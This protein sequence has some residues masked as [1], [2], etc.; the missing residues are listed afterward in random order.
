MN[1]LQTPRRSYRAL[2]KWI[3]S[4]AESEF[5]PQERMQQVRVATTIGAI[6]GFLFSLFNLATP[7]MQT[8]GLIELFAVACLATPALII[9]RHRH[10]VGFAETMLLLAAILI[11]GA[12]IVLGGV[13][14]TGLFW[15][16]TT[17]FLAFF[18]KG[19]RLGRFY[20]IG[21]LIAAA[22][23][24]MV[25]APH[26][27]FARHY[28][29]VISFHFL[30]SLGFYTLVA[31]A[32]D[33]V[34]TRYDDQLRKEKEKAE[35]AYMAK[36]RFL[37]AA[38]HDLRQPAHALG[39]F[40]SRLLQMPADSRTSEIVAGVDASTRA[41][42]EMLDVFF[43]YSRLESQSAEVVLRPVAL[44]TLLEQL[45][46]FFNG[47]AAEKGLRLRFR[48]TGAWVQ[49]DPVLLQRIL[50]NLVSNAL[51]YTER[52]TVL[53]ACRPSHDRAHLR[54]EVWDSGIGIAREHHKKIFEEFFQVENQQR[55]RTKGLGLGLS[56]VGRSCRILNHPLELRSELGCGSRF[57]LKVPLAP[58]GQTKATPHE[59]TSGLAIGDTDL[60]NMHILLIEDDALGSSALV[61]LLQSWGCSV[62]LTQSAQDALERVGRMP[63][64]DF[65]VSDF[66]LS[67]S[68]NGVE[69]IDLLRE[70]FGSTLK[71][72]L[73]SGDT[74]EDVK[75]KA[76]TASLVLLQK[77]VAPGKLRSVL[78]RSR[79]NAAV[80]ATAP[81]ATRS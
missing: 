19:Q 56:M 77:P 66:R 33:Y 75:R 40:V 23:Y 1:L 67:G 59:S 9:S 17:P 10:F 35:A 8:L 63:V 28:S 74:G 49:S 76:A 60:H 32:F 6:V 61:G 36:S 30:L 20:S 16:Y 52:G 42:Q 37:A 79:S 44:R 53:V 26:L 21:F 39:M 27:D 5:A 50:L 57:T 73:I 62:T 69:A 81:T 38:S 64:P 47:I 24:L 45:G 25:L 13:E 11:F 72:C 31:A 58:A 29:P 22:F 51:Q 12:L 78:R 54:I 34:R 48:D 71:A 18:L 3:T 46:F 68:R 80:A 65:V 15:V 14:S 55:D 4:R 2:R 41:L 70:H 7:G 43:D